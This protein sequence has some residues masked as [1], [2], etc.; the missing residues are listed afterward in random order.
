MPKE[1][2]F[3]IAGDSG[4]VSTWSNIPYFFTKTLI[5]KGIKVDRVD[6]S[7]TLHYKLFTIGGGKFRKFLSLFFPNNQYYYCKSPLY[8]HLT[9]RLIKKAV[10]KYSNADLCIMINFDF[11]NKFSNIPTLLF[12][13]WTYKI[14]ILEHLGRKPY[15]FEKKFFKCEKE[16]VER[17]DYVVSLFPECAKMMRED[18]PNA[19]IHYLGG[20]VVNS[21]YDKKHDVE[22]FIEQKKR[23]K[24]ILFIGRE[25][26]RKG[27]LLLIEALKLLREKEEEISLDIIGMTKGYF[28]NLPDYVHC[29]GYLHKEI[30]EERKLYYDLIIGARLFANPTEL[31]AGFSSTIEAM[32][33][34]TPV[35]VSPYKDFVGDFGAEIDFGTYNKEFSAVQ[36]AKNILNVI[37]S[38]DYCALCRNAYKRVKNYTWDAYVDRILKLVDQGKHEGQVKR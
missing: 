26:Y 2:I 32:Y 33:F 11:Y 17:A 6:L 4:N 38:P 1:I 14:E 37:N 13:D 3:F 20:N 31:W 12:G 29:H 27:A 21:F 25:H 24:R 19:N 30:E 5:E 16:A 36:L 18:Y 10:R 35:V 23:S 7:K 8:V 9:Y 28:H 34:A 15:F 22:S